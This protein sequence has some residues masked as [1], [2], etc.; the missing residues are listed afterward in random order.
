MGMAMAVAGARM[1]E[2]VDGIGD[3]QLGLPTP[4][5]EY[6][7]ADLL[8]HMDQVTRGFA[9]L[10]RGEVDQK[11]TDGLEDGWRDRLGRQ[12]TELGEVWGDA[13][14]RE[15][16]TEVSGLE[17]PDRTWGGIA[18]TEVVVHGWDLAQATGQ[19]FELPAE[20]LRA[21]FEHVA[22]FVPKAPVPELWGPPVA[23]PGDAALLDRIVAITG[24][25]P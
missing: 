9:A 6:R 8:A 24:R 10:G 23:V 18:L 11:V 20:T 1:A 4:C 12:L 22:E 16:V 19:P 21:C 14:A 2:L 3:G 13:R 17:L 25:V 7:V 15:G 5:D